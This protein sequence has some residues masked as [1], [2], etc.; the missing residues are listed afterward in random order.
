MSGKDLLRPTLAITL[1][2]L[3]VKA[4]GF[5]EK[6]V[7]AYYYGADAQVDA[8]FVALS[9]PMGL[10][11]AGREIAE[12]TFLPLFV[13]HLDSGRKREAWQVFAI[14]GLGLGGIAL[15][16]GLAATLG[17]GTLASWLA[18]GFSDATRELTA[19]LI[20]WVAPAGVL[21]ALS[22][23][24][25]LAL[26]GYRIFAWAAA[27]DLLLKLG[28]IVFV[29]ALFHRAG[30]LALA[31]GLIAGAAARIVFHG[32]RLAKELSWLHWPGAE[33]RAEARRIAALGAP[34]LGL[35]VASQVGEFADNHFSSQVGEGGVAA[36][37]FARK[38]IDL[39]ILMIPGAL[40]IVA[41]PAFSRLAARG[42][43]EELLQ[44]LARLLRGL[45]MFFAFVSLCTAMLAVP[46]VK[47]LFERGAFDATASEATARALAFYA[48]GMLVVSFE[49]LL[50]P[51]FFSLKDTRTPV[52]AH[53]VGVT[54][55]VF[56]ASWL[57]PSLGIRGVA[58]ALVAGKGLK[59][60]L[61]G[62]ALRIRWTSEGLLPALGA[63]LRI[64]LATAVAG[65]A[66]HFIAI[67]WGTTT[68]VVGEVLRMAL[69]TLGAAVA[70]LAVFAA[71]PSP[72]R[73]LLREG[74]RWLRRAPG[75]R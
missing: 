26:N 6:Q 70:F 60:L 68:G 32:F 13:Q 42:D 8:Y 27:A 48:P 17:A 57:W 22:A 65:L 62:L 37:T 56:L 20:Q 55:Q 29:V 3:L 63:G 34:L 39:P 47:L 52:A 41:F 43:H 59:V 10:F 72:E 31:Y 21:L 73:D 44:L 12:P 38:I 25:A 11:L 33:S 58:L 40:S 14:V 64:A 35:V 36:R 46:V 18:P 53:I 74:L 50:M 45:A 24:T 1:I 2:S 30:V 19:E 5:V 75:K 9:V 66:L 49:A 61:L 28:P 54:F 4:V 23:L 71:M 51:F 16:I 69:A 67:A 7:V 15:V